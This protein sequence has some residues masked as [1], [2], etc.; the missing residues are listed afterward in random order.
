MLDQ[1][2]ETG[3]LSQFLP[4]EWPEEM[5]MPGFITFVNGFF[6][7]YVGVFINLEKCNNGKFFLKQSTQTNRLQS[8]LV[9]HLYSANADTK[10]A[11]RI[12]IIFFPF[13]PKKG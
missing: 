8:G 10:V 7:L 13:T 11:S 3:P 6:L 9:K 12:S 1:T 2:S 4:W 5:P